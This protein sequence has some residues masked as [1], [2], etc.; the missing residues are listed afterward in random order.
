MQ[1]II[2]RGS[3]N[4]LLDTDVQQITFLDKRFYYVPDSGNYLP[5]VTTILDAYPKGPA[6]YEWLKKMG[7]DADEVRDDA[8]NVGSN[9]HRL[10][11]QYDLGEYVGILNE[12]GE[13]NLQLKEWH[14]FEK[15]VDF[16]TRFGAEMT[17]IEVQAMDEELG[18]AGT[19]DRI[20]KLNGEYWLMDI[21]TANYMHN[22]FWLQQAAYRALLNKKGIQIDRVGILHLNSLH[23]TEGKKGDIQG[24]G[25]KLYDKTDTSKDLELFNATHKLWLAEFGTMKPKC[26]SYKLAHQLPEEHRPETEEYKLQNILQP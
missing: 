8:G 14:M 2:Q 21:K 16:R 24:M 5:S 10:T 17:H 26:V 11:E 25:W 23:R 19:L 13:V 3:K 4:Y 1:K 22:H 9:V 7:E 20:F 18:Y 12:M 15:Y 6:F